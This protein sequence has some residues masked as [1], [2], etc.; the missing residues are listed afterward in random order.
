MKPTDDKAIEKIAEKAEVVRVHEEEVDLQEPVYLIT[1]CPSPRMLPDA[2]FH[3]QHRYNINTLALF[4]KSCK[5]GLFCVEATQLG[6]PHYHGWYQ[7]DSEKELAR[8]SLVKLLEKLGRVEITRSH[9][10]RINKY[11]ETRNA[12]WYYKKDLVGSMLIIDVNP[13]S[14]ESH[15]DYR[16]DLT[17][18]FD[19]DIKGKARLMSHVVSER[20]RLMKFY[21]NSDY[22]VD[23]PDPLLID[24]I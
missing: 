7:V 16:W 6:R 21:Q 20:D 14:R 23:P 15:D 12:L 18:F 10:V 9:R 13:I 5:C 3:F 2:D 24:E 8:I 1:W 11:T 17:P 22:F 4:L 19:S